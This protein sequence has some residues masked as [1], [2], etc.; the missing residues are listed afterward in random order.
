MREGTLDKLLST[1]EV[2]A[3]LGVSPRTV[4]RL[5]ASRGLPH[6]RLG[7]MVRFAPADV[8]RWVEARKE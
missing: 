2:A 6:I 4:K 3:I 1:N 8:Y 7:R 5:V